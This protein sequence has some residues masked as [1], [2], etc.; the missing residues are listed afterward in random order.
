MKQKPF[1]NALEAG[2]LWL[3]KTIFLV[4]GTSLISAQSLSKTEFESS[5]GY[6]IG[7]L[8]PMTN[9]V[10]S[11]LVTVDEM[12][13]TPYVGMQFIWL[14]SSFPDAD[15]Y[16]TQ[17]LDSSPMNDTIYADFYLLPGV[18]PSFSNLP[19]ISNYPIA[20][21][22]GL[23]NTEDSLGELVFVYGNGF[24][25]L[26]KIDSLFTIHSSLFLRMGN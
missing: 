9:L 20:A 14:P 21:M 15:S 26:T 23:V 7:V 13:P 22:T 12:P 2:K 5:E 10:A 19:E 6:M 17:T 18:V 3:L 24:G 16:Q 4:L 11:E 8:N 25:D 1:F